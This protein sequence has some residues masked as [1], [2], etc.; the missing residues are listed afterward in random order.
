MNYATIVLLSA[1][2]TVVFYKGSIFDPLR[3]HGPE[4]WRDLAMCPLCSGVWIGGAVT[5]GSCVQTAVLSWFHVLFLAVALGSLTGCIALLFARVS[6]WLESAAV[7]HDAAAAKDKDL[8][9]AWKKLDGQLQPFL[10]TI[11]QAVTAE[12]FSSGKPP[13]S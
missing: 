13:P 11:Q 8:L 6:D 12:L 5:V 10:R 4:L 9:E 1:A 2:I 7:A 3:Q